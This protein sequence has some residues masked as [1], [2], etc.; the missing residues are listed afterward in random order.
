LPE[1]VGTDVMATVRSVADSRAAVAAAVADSSQTSSYGCIQPLVI[2]ARPVILVSGRQVVCEAASAAAAAVSSLVVAVPL[3]VDCS[4]K[5][6]SSAVTQNDPQST[7]R[8]QQ[9]RKRKRR[10][11]NKVSCEKF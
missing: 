6:N 2:N 9:K 4:A 5:L 1:V 10:R 11:K 7:S 3:S 8:Q